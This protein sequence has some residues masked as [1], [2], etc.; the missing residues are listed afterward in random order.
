MMRRMPLAAV[1]VWAAAG[2]CAEKPKEPDPKIAA[3]HPAA[4]RA[5][6]S[7]AAVVRGSDLAGARSLVFEGDGVQ[8][9]V[10]GPGSE[11]GKEVK[12]KITVAADAPAGGHE[13]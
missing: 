8:G 13:F 5:G 9:S 7:V 11:E 3:I 4:A 1:L 10:I 2:M 6:T 12:V